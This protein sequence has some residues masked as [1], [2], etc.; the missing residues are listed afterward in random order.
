MYENEHEDS[1]VDASE[2]V[3][4]IEFDSSDD[5]EHGR[6]TIS[7]EVISQ[8]AMRA[9]ASV[10]GVVPATP[11]LMSNFRLGRKSLGG[12]RISMSDTEPPVI[13]AE[14]FIS[15]RCGLRIPDVGC[16]VQEA[17]KTQVEK[18]SGYVVK[19]VNVYVQ[20]MIFDDEQQPEGELSDTE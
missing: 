20:G 9:L 5:N 13:V 2:V 19:S 8:I 6:V 17:I 4:T 16:N 10:E 15:V 1:V 18:L 3:D 14:A 7:E 12:V 11:G